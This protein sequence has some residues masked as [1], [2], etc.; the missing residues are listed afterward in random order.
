MN[1][2][3]SISHV[4]KHASHFLIRPSLQAW[5]TMCRRSGCSSQQWD[6]WSWCG[7]QRQDWRYSHIKKW[8]IDLI[9][10]GQSFIS[11]LIVRIAEILVLQHQ[12]Y[13]HSISRAQH[14]PESFWTSPQSFCGLLL[15]YNAIGFAWSN[16]IEKAGCRTNCFHPANG[17]SNSLLI[18]CSLSVYC[19]FVKH[20]TKKPPQ[21]TATKST[22]EKLTPLWHS[23]NKNSTLQASQV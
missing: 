14:D 11:F 17:C 2:I 16:S 21:P 20:K 7:L 13:L 4:L 10:T 12:C 3:Y 22:R 6:L 23:V 8:M 1:G 18:F 5:N 19:K 9:S 15:H